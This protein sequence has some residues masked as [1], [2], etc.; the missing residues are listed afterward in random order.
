MM[1]MSIRAELIMVEVDH[2]N[3]DHGPEDDHE[4]ETA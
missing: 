1:I 3:V 2:V 4:K